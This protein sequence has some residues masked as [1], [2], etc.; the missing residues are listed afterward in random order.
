MLLPKGSMQINEADFK[1]FIS[2]KL[3][4]S[5]GSIKNCM[6]RLRIINEWFTDKDLSK[7]NVEQF[8]LELKTRGLKNNSL[9]TYQF[10]FRHIASFCKDRGLPSDF[11][12]GFKAFKKT[13]AD[14]IIF[15]LEEIEQILKHHLPME[16][17]GG[18]IARFLISGTGRLRCF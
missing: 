15:T 9:N 8:L 7:E 6:I 18:K 3:G 5:E 13:K 1:S 17:S 11:F 10:A 4:L 14:I 2:I 16:S 12:D